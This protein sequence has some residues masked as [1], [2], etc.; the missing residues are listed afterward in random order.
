VVVVS[1]GVLVNVEDSRV[2]IVVTTASVLQ[3]KSNLNIFIQ[4]FIFMHSN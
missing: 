4:I 3:R 2:S 1:L